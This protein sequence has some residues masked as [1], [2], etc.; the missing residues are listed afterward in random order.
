MKISQNFVAFSEYTN[1]TKLIINDKGV[2]HAQLRPIRYHLEP[3]ETSPIPQT[4]F[5]M[6]YF[7]ASYVYQSGFN[8]YLATD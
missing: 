8:S 3:S 2:T 6:D 1:F 5:L 4:S 7:A